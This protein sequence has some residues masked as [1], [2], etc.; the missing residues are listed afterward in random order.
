MP[1]PAPLPI[2]ETRSEIQVAKREFVEG[3]EP[4]CLI[5]EK[6]IEAFCQEDNELV[7]I[8]C[9][10]SNEHKGHTLHSIEKA[11]DMQITYIGK[12]YEKSKEIKAG[13]QKQK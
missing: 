2:S 1:A 4:L 5:H 12:E 8:S 7:C 11:I 13:I 6:Q 9:I 10:L 3:V